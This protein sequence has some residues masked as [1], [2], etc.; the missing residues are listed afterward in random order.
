MEGKE[1]RQP[2]LNLQ[3]FYQAIERKKKSERTHVKMK[4]KT[5]L[6][7]MS[8]IPVI[9]E[10]PFTLEQFFQDFKPVQINYNERFFELLDISEYVLYDEK[11]LL[12]SILDNKEKICFDTSSTNIAGE[13]NIIN[14]STKYIV[15]KTISSYIINKAWA[16]LDRGRMIWSDESFN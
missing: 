3:E 6:N 10:I 15:T 13:W 14:Y 11:Y 1:K 5:P 16:W 12:F 7:S 9:S 2:M 4:S 8:E